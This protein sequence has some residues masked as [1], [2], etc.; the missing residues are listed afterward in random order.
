MKRHLLTAITLAVLLAFA[1]LAAAAD[2]L[3][4]WNEGEAKRSVVDFVQRVTTAGGADFVPVPERIAVFDND[5]TLW[6]EKPMYVQLAFALDRVKALVPEHPEWAINWDDLIN[7]NT[8]EED[9]LRAAK[10]KR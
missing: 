10:R 7:K 5:G 3:P 9:I 8:R 1:P 2:P 6:A 4:S